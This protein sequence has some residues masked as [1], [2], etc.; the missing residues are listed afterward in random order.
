ML[1][2]LRKDCRL[3]VW[4]CIGLVMPG[5]RGQEFDCTP[6]AQPKRVTDGSGRATQT[7]TGLDVANNAYIATVIDEKIKVRIIGPDLDVD[8]PVEA[9]GLAQGD[10]DFATNSSGITFLSFSQ[11]DE[12]DQGRDVYLTDNQGGG[13]KFRAPQ[14]VSRSRT[15]EYAP[16]LVLDQSGQ[17][18][19]AWAQSVDELTRVMYW[20][21]AL[22][23]APPIAAAQGDY[24]HL[25]VDSK[26]VVHLVYSRQNDIYYNNN[27]GGSFA[28]ELRV[29]TTATE[30]E[31]SASIGV[32]PQGNVMI[33]FE[34]R[35]SLYYVTK[36][37]GS[38]AFRPPLLVDSGG[39]LNPRM[40]VRSRGQVTI[41]YA[42]EGDINFVIGQSTFLAF[43]ERICV[44]T[45]PV[46]SHPSLEI[47]LQGNVHVSF[48]RD[49]EV[50]YTNNAATPVAE[51]SG[52][53]TV[54]EVP[55]TVRFGDLSSGGVQVWEWDFGDGATSSEPNPVHTYTTPAEYDV[56][57]TVYG[58]GGVS[59]K[60]VKRKFIFVQDPFYTMRIPDQRV[61]PGQADVWFPVI[62]GRKERTQGYQI[63]ATYDPNYLVFKTVEFANTIISGK[64][65]EF[66]EANDLGT[67]LDIG[68]IY[69]F[70]DPIDLNNVYLSPGEGQVLQQLVFDVSEGA[71]QGAKTRVDLV[72]NYAISRIFNIFIVDG[73]TRL[74]AL[75]GST[76]EI[77]VVAPPFPR[78]FLRGDA[79][80]NAKVEITDAIRI[81][82]YLFLGGVPPVCID[83]ADVNDTGRIDISSAVALLNFLFLGGP[84]PA[85]PFPNQG[86]DPTPDGVPDC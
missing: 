51:F 4:A 56:T 55:L 47:D 77:Q 70:V 72:N 15:D 37:T 45:D 24:P 9:T 36:L 44:P 32:D 18:H 81:L 12:L 33:C 68:C 79:D 11:L 49:G 16:R 65:R 22:G 30:P 57:L 84:Q 7:A 19:L 6:Y 25:Y 31:S 20:S 8:V 83:A 75:T 54:G 69:E 62:T 2:P 21:R 39:I 27:S 42:K 10:P 48:L 43:P 50:Y 5:I 63:M 28:N 85:V 23:D 52:I 67:H 78:F 73:Y 41:V 13:G 64:T 1:N 35:H 80:G 53:P 46:E 86:L 14:N 29:T 40:R 17:P 60:K 66:F 26:D 58:P 74:P 76:V 61:F 59:N 71:P 82:N 3:A 34:S 38:S